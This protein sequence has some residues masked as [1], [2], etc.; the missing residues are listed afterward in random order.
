MTEFILIVIFFLVLNGLRI[1]I[2]RSYKIAYYEQKLKNRGVD[3]EHVKNISL[4][5]IINQ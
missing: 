1:G 5:Q 3:I 4:T 2:I